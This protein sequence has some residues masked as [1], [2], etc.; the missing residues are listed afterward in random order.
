MATHT[1]SIPAPTSGAAPTRR[2]IL[3]AFTGAAF[4]GTAVVLAPATRAAETQDDVPLLALCAEYHRLHA[5][6]M[7]NPGDD[8]EHEAIGD[9]LCRLRQDTLNE[10]AETP[11][12]TDAGRFAKAS[13]SL[14]GLMFDAAVFL[15]IPWREH[16]GAETVI[17]IDVLRSL[18]GGAE[19]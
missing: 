12:A 15:D 9:K 1:H 19:A 16:A 18:V 10:I 3:S 4:A 6:W 13:V 7:A 2:L 8:R 11:H 14:D 5:A 17:A